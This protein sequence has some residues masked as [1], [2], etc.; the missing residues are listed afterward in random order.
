[1]RPRR[2]AL[3]SLCVLVATAALA[4]GCKRGG[5]SSAEADAGAAPAGLTAEQ[6]AK[7]VA[8]VGDRVIT[9][10]DFATALDRMDQ[11][12]RLRYQ[13]P[14]RRK[15]LLD[16]MIDVELLADDARKKGLD[17]EPET[18]EAVRQIL[19]DALLAEVRKGVRAPADIPAADVS[20]WY[21]AHPD[22]YRDPERRR[23]AAI[24]CKDEATATKAIGEA[25]KATPM[26]W[27]ELVQKYSAE[28][29]P[30]PGPGAPLEL[31]GDLGLVGAPAEPRGDNKRVPPEVR[32]AVFQLDKVGDVVDKPVKVAGG[33]AVVRMTGKNDAHVR[34][35]QEADRSIRVSIVQ[36]EIADREKKL[37]ADLRAK[38]PVTV[39]DKALAAVQMPGQPQEAADAGTAATDASAPR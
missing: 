13:S 33:F 9:V 7:I 4:G 22:D 25:K 15:E 37:E 20:A 36:N 21:Q 17:K 23:V 35:L 8:R 6:A 11:F 32:A 5:S 26:Q 27:G 29:V 18:Q 2:S 28:P 14:E 12:D 19:R 31:S 3:T 39:D 30:K 24:V 34:T 10:G 16:E 1:M 38:F